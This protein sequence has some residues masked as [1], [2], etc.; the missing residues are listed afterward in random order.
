[1]GHK[2][3]TQFFF[4][5]SETYFDKSQPAGKLQ[6]TENLRRSQTWASRHTGGFHS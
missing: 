4:P 1:M 2:S 3:L 6:K 5:L